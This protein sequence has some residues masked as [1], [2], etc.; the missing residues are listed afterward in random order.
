MTTLRQRTGRALAL[1][2]A[3]AALASCTAHGLGKGR[4]P[5]VY[6]N[7]TPYSEAFYRELMTGRVH[8]YAARAGKLRNVV[9]GRF[10]ASDGAL[11]ECF[12]AR[13]DNK[14]FWIW[15]ENARWS[16]VKQRSGVRIE[17]HRADGHKGYRSEFYDP[18]TGSFTSEYLKKD[19]WLRTHPG[20]IQDSWPRALAN[21]NACP[22]LKRR[23]QFRINEKQTSLKMDELRRQDPEAPIRNFPGSHLRAP[24]TTG[25]GASRG[26]P[27]T[28]AEEVD[29]YL[30]AQE[31]NILKSPAG[32][33]FVYVRSEGIGEFWAV[34]EDGA[35]KEFVLP[36]GS[37]DGKKITARMGGRDVVY[38]VGYPFPFRPTGHRHPAFQL[39]DELIARAELLPLP[40]MGERYEGYRFLFHDKTLT[41]VAPGETYL[42]GR[43]RWT[44]GYLQVWLDGEEQHA[45]SIARRDLAR[46]LGVTPTVWT[47]F[48]P[49]KID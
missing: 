4:D 41:V 23:A 42:E 21:A 19:R 6:V 46:E 8:L 31:G 24:G 40:W 39:T 3:G 43:W 14:L 11:F 25:L 16:L 13:G 30:L 34:G 5:R 44:K 49:D 12:P 36:V 10:F 38:M 9:G 15:K 28:T 26:A 32:N 27:T 7:Y 33:G 2:L 47:P 45:G 35:E 37:P 29:A 17:R 1:V 48:T 18:E 22:I 20:V